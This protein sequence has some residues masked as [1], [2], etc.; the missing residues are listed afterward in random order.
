MLIDR[1][2]VIIGAAALAAVR[3]HRCEGG[4]GK[5]PQRSI[6]QTARSGRQS[7]RAVGTCNPRITLEQAGSTLRPSLAE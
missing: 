1:R 6:R 5:I 4:S 7:N 3:T 2:K